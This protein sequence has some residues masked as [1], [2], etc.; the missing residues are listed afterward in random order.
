MIDMC[1]EQYAK[2]M[3]NWFKGDARSVWQGLRHIAGITKN[4]LSPDIKKNVK[5]IVMN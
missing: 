1:K 2:E 5:V 4:F 3:N